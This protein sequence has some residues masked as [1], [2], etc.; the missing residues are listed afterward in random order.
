MPQK[1][2]Q[3]ISTVLCTALPQALLTAQMMRLLFAMFLS[4]IF[5]SKELALPSPASNCRRSPPLAASYIAEQRAWRSRKAAAE[6]NY[7]ACCSGRAGP[8]ST[9]PGTHP[10]AGFALL[11]QE[12][13]SMQLSDHRLVIVGFDLL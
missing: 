4:I 9:S 11:D 3:A 2:E 1:R 8:V 13:A 6:V 10:A 12:L 5:V 7:A